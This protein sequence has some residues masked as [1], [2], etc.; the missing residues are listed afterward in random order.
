MN[1][2]HPTISILIHISMAIR[3]AEKPHNNST[4]CMVCFNSRAPGS[5]GP[6]TQYYQ[7]PVCAPCG[8]QGAQ[9]KCLMRDLWHPYLGFPGPTE[10]ENS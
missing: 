5:A 1:T 6:H 7:G 3:G 9:G 8:L 4:T 2:F 10:A